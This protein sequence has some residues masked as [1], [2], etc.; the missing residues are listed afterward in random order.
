MIN[1][2][3]LFGT[4]ALTGCV[5]LGPAYAEPDP[6]WSSEKGL[7]KLA[8]TS[9]LEPIEINRIH[10]WLLHI[11]TADGDLVEN[12]EVT[13]DGGMPVHNHGLPTRPTVTAYLGNGDY[14]VEGLRFHMNG[15]WE[16]WISVKSGSMTDIVTI[17]LQL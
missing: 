2:Q 12:A 15:Q 6:V 17:P 4:L 11:E 10:E 13:V 5:V 1:W 7:Y 8:Y 14:R 16:I 3:K 9:A